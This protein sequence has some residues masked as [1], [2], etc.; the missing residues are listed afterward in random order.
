MMIAPG[1]EFNCFVLGVALVVGALLSCAPVTP[2]PPRQ[3][4]SSPIIRVGLLEHR[5][6]VRIEPTGPFYI[7]TLKPNPLKLVPS[8]GIWKIR[9]RS[10]NP[11]QQHYRIRLF[12]S[13]RKD[14]ARD[15]AQIFKEKYRSVILETEG[16]ELMAGDRPILDRRFYSV[17]LRDVFTT[18]SSAEAKIYQLGINH[19]EIVSFV[20]KS[21][22]GQLVLEAPNGKS[23]LIDNA[24]RFTGPPIKV[25]DIDVGKGFHWQRDE[26]RIY[27]SEIEVYIDRTGKLSVINVLPL[28]LYL[29]GVVPGEMSHG[30]PLEA[31]KAQAV[32][33]RT[34]FL[35]HFARKHP[36]S[37]FDV[38][39][40]VHCQAFVGKSRET[41][42]TNTAVAETRGVV[43]VYN[44]DLCSTPYSAVCGGHTEDASSAWHSDGEPYLT[45]HYDLPEKLVPHSFDLRT[46]PSA[47]AWIDATPP[48]YC[49]LNTLEEASWADYAKKYLRWQIELSRFDLQK[50]IR[51]FTNSDIG[52]ITDLVPLRRGVSGRISELDIIGTRGKIHLERELVIRRTLSPSTLYS[53]CF[54]V[55]KRGNREL[56][57]TFVLKGAGWGHGVGMCQIGA[58]SMAAKG[59]DYAKILRHYYRGIE[60]KRLY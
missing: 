16:E 22:R 12:S 34:F 59:I 6:E 9:V 29:Q 40:D 32:A 35:Y 41:E 14:L 53:S 13:R 42:K 52:D 50:H 46:E 23:V 51:Q 55:E 25:Y 17:F 18:R 30:F 48:V 54:V 44:D 3:D 8:N 19:A 1:K 47:R 38:C 37:D 28:Q 27:R 56:P 39:D 5:D 57:H 10:G 7:L 2:P 58:S 36:N 26:N 31:L 49:N 45:G 24:L 43:M 15:K 33:A 11:A 20:D 60:L 4:I 21:A